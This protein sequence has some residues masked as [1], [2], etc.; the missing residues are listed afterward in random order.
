MKLTKE[1]REGILAAIQQHHVKRHDTFFKTAVERIAGCKFF[2]YR[3]FSGVYFFL[4]YLINGS[5][6]SDEFFELLEQNSII[7]ENFVTPIPKFE[8]K[9]FDGVVR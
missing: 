9:A 6:T 2:W 8:G 1:M 3:P 5:V 7:P 4:D